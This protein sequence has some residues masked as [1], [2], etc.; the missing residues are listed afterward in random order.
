MAAEYVSGIHQGALLHGR[1]D[2]GREFAVQAAV[3][4]PIQHLDDVCGIAGIR[5]TRNHLAH[6]G[7]MQDL[8]DA[9]AMCGAGQGGG[10]VFDAQRQPERP[11]GVFEKVGVAGDDEVSRPIPLG[12]R[13][14][15]VR[16]Y[17][18]GFSRRDD[19]PRY[20]HYIWISEMT[21]SRR[22]I[23]S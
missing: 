18:R 9:G 20:V 12:Q 2:H 7:N 13:D 6:G 3:A 4:G 10:I 11:G 17:A 15:G 8:E 5:L 23:T 1:G 19:D 14:A 21:Q 22:M 16:P